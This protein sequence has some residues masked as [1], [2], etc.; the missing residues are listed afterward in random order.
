M[1]T[2]APAAPDDAGL[3][4]PARTLAI[5]SVLAAMVLVVLSAAV[6]HLALP[7]LARTFEVTPAAAVRVVG[8]Y[9]LGLVVALLPSAAL[10]DRLGHRAVF[11]AGVGLFTGASV[12]SAL[13]PSLA[14][15]VA[16]RFV[17]G[18]GGSAV[19][20]L[21]VALLRVVVGSGAL[22]AA[23]GWNALAVALSSAAA[24]TVGALLLAGASW[25]WL[26]AFPVP[27]GVAVL[28]AARALPETPPT[29]PSPF[30]PLDLLESPPFRS[31]MLASVACFAGQTAALIALPF[32]LQHGFG[33]DA[34]GTA[35]LTTPWPLAVAL[36]AP[37]AGRLADHASSAWLSSAGAAGLA[38]GLAA[39]AAV[40][41]R[42][43]ALVLVPF[44]VLCGVGFGLFQV[45]NNRNM[46]LAAPR[47]RSAAA[48]ALQGTARL[49]G[50]TLGAGVASALF[51]MAP[52]DAA[53]RLAL[54]AGA[55]LTLLAGIVSALRADSRR[56]AGAGA[57]AD[58]RETIAEGPA[59][60]V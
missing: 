29:G 27:L 45:S 22:G 6:V 52:L 51:A 42:G 24:P 53:P 46:F 39:L 56:A 32:H 1:T 16:A 33:Q 12:L 58:R 41:T 50:Q 34:L 18:L 13:A 30:V 40:S 10:G 21:G 60:G 43:S 36:V 11:M 57:P 4:G 31:S 55:A 9:Q 17:Q 19:M 25:P 20:A 37:V 7:A 59:Q 15:L 28:A 5:A 47:A 38:L 44:V 2:L 3:R 54:G 8:A 49:T 35:L 14:W 26:F 23:I 48:G